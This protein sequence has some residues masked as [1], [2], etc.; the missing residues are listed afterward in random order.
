[1]K[2]R[3]FIVFWKTIKPIL[4]FVSFFIVLSCSQDSPDSIVGNL[5]LDLEN[6]GIELETI[7]YF[8]MELPEISTDGN[9]INAIYDPR[10]KIISEKVIHLG[11]KEEK[12]YPKGKL[13]SFSGDYDLDL[14]K[15]KT[16][17]GE[18][19]ICPTGSKYIYFHYAIRNEFWLD[20]DKDEDGSH[21]HP[22]SRF[23]DGPYY[24]HILDS[25]DKNKIRYKVRIYLDPPIDSDVIKHTTFGTLLTEYN[26]K[27]VIEILREGELDNRCAT[28]DSSR[29]RSD[30]IVGTYI[31]RLISVFE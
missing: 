28:I 29:D 31:G 27:A 4:I 20:T 23:E 13:I 11:E 24:E 10:G 26:S 5:E 17:I 16:S 19:L 30:T 18:A 21:L 22:Y 7:P 8:D 6:K 15:Y 2:S 14:G 25:E 12:Y 1:M 3:I 9:P